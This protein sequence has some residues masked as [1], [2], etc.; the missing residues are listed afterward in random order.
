M[1]YDNDNIF[2]KILQNPAYVSSFRAF[3]S[4]QNLIIAPNGMISTFIRSSTLVILKKRKFLQFEMK[5]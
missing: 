1:A 5:S 4:L 2:A 3:F